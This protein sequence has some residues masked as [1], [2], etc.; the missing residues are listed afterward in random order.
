MRPLETDLSA[1]NRIDFEKSP[2]GVKYLFFRPEGMEQLPIEKNLAFCEMLTEAQTAKAPFYFSKENNETCVGKILLG[3]TEMEPFA[4]AGEIGPRLGMVQEPRVN[5]NFYHHVPRLSKG[6]VNYVAFAPIDKLTFEPDVLIITANPT[7][8]EIIMRAMTYSTGEPYTSK[9]TIFMG[10]S[11]IY[12]YPFETGKV[13]YLMPEMIHG[14]TGRE[15]FAPNTILISIPYQWLQ[16]VAKN[17]GEIKLE[18]HDNK[19][20][21]LAEFEGILIDLVEKSKNP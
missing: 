5:H 6:I 2:V 15:I 14:M 1:F 17:L 19:E 13:N 4:E 3:M 11:W 8:A 10:C 9:T 16:T 20:E 18:F 21:Y 7:Q 12:I